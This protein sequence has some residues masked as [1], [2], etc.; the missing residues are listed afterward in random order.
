MSTYYKKHVF[1]CTNQKKEG[2]QCCEQGNATEMFKYTKRRCKEEGLKANN[3][4]RVS[5]A[6]CLG[7]CSKGP[8][9]VV[10]PEGRWYHYDSQA[11]IDKI[12]D[13]ELCEDEVVESLLIDDPL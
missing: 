3:N 10:Y 13:S 9:L 1:F 8:C 12:I 7:R 5:K 11:D 2:K 4:V 6:G